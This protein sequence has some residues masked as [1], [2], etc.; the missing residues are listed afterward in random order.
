M[1]LLQTINLSFSGQAGW[2]GVEPFNHSTILN[3]NI[4]TQGAT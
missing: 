2:A 3:Y 1:E 4:G